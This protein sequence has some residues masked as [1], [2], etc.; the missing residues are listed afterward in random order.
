MVEDDRTAIIQVNISRAGLGVLMCRKFFARS[1]V[2]P[3]HFHPIVFKL[4]LVGL[5]QDFRRV[6]S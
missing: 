4:E 2:N 5:R 1:I 3:G 6:L